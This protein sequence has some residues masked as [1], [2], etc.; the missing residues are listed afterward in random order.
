MTVAVELK[1]ILHAEKYLEPIPYRH[2]IDIRGRITRS[3]VEEISRVK[4]EPDW[5]RRLRLRALEYFE[6]LPTPKWLYGIESIDLEE[7]TTYYIKPLEE[8]VSSWDELPRDI[9]EIYER[10]GLPETYAKYLAGLTTVLDSETVYSSMKKYLEKLGVVMIPMEKAV[11]KY[12]DIVKK[13]FAHIVS[14]AEHKFA[15]LHYALWSGGVFVYIPKNVKVPYPIEAFFFVGKELEGQFE[16][17]LIIVDENAELTF[18]EGCSAP[19]FKRF[20]FHDG[21]VELYAHKRS[22]ITF[23]TVQNWSR[24][25][26]NF[27]NKRA[28]AEEE[29]Y[30]EW[31][32]GSVGSKYTATY[33]STILKGRGASSSSIVVGITNGPYIKDTGSKMIHLAPETR[34]RI[35]SKS[36]SSM[37]GVNIYRGLVYVSEKAY[38]ARSYTQC[39]SLIL[40]E[41]SKAYTY[42][43]L[44]VKNNTAEIGH[45]AT[46]GRIS[47]EQLFYLETRGLNEGEAKSLIVLGFIRDVLKGLPMEYVAMLSKVIQLE[48]EKI[49]GVA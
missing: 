44:E 32:E 3:L 7:I 39:D 41:R 4:K 6:K 34:S 42:P 10:L 33:P 15:A 5:M 43:I 36:I 25:I 47:E 1:D 19:R 18:I 31:L 38:N 22:K 40:D 12:P 49:G 28:I 26:I 23:V 13:Y 14:Y 45:E 30:V 27:N 9:R 11:E 2:E 37:G 20:S 24:N 35:V 17:S 46:T 48:F 29:S 16:H 21:A 8:P